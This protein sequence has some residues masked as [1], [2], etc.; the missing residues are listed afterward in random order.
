MALVDL[1]GAGIADVEGLVAAVIFG[2][3]LLDDVGLNSDAEVIGLASE[4]GGDVVVLILLEGVVAEIAP[5]NS[6]HAEF[7]GLGEGVA[8][9]D[10]LAVGLVGAEIDGG[11]NGGGAH[12]VGFPPRAEKN[13]VGLSGEG[14]EVVVSDFSEEGIFWRWF[15]GVEGE[16]RFGFGGEE[17]FDVG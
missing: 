11:S 2:E 8:D 13:L 14:A 6:G 17:L 16:E 5:E 3:L 15:A 12:V 7:V 10:D 9:F 1:A 4:V